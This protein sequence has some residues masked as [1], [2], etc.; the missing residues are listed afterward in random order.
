MNK[1][2]KGTE[3]E[4]KEEEENFVFFSQTPDQLKNKHI[5][6]DMKRKNERKLV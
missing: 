6:G 2:S 4:T 1:K 3:K 5:K